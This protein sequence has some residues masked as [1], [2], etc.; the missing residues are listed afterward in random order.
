M[1]HK[2]YK[3]NQL[4][5]RSVLSDLQRERKKAKSLGYESTEEYEEGLSVV[6]KLLAR[7]SEKFSAACGK[8]VEISDEPPVVN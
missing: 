7:K 5:K 4:R 2:K 1:G 8:V 6:K 3:R